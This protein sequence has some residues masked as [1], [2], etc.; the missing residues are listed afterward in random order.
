MSRGLQIVLALVGLA[1]AGCAG[2]GP[3]GAGAS[4][5]DAPAG[6]VSRTADKAARQPVGTFLTPAKAY[7][8]WRARPDR[9]HILDVRTPAEYIFVGHGPMARNIP[10][11][12]LTHKWD[13]AKKQ[14]VM[15]PNPDFI[16]QVRKAYRPDD[17]IL[18]MCQSGL[19]GAAAVGR[20][21]AAGFT[22]VQ[23]IHGGFEGDVR[24]DCNCPDVGK[25]TVNGWKNSALAWTYDLEPELM[26]LP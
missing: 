16:A 17:T 24:K 18:V 10:L 23:N 14:P 8:R 6:R 5:R 25:R 12:F 26:Y 3:W 11:K 19:R 7:Q 1:V 20:M 15:R 13:P 22:D 2:S 4:A 21:R 9:V